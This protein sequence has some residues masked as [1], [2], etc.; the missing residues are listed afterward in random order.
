MRDLWVRKVANRLDHGLRD[1]VFHRKSVPKRTTYVTYII[2]I[3]RLSM[4]PLFSIPLRADS[5]LS[6]NLPEHRV[7]LALL[8]RIRRMVQ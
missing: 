7:V 5:E 2:T 1:L 6:P 8:D 3:S 4:L